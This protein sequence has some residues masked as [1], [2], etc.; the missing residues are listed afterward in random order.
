[1]LFL[2]YDVGTLDL[3]Q[4][5]DSVFSRDASGEI[6]DFPTSPIQSLLLPKLRPGYSYNELTCRS[7][8]KPNHVPSTADRSQHIP[9]AENLRIGS[10]LTSTPFSKRPFHHEAS[11]S[12]VLF[13]CYID[14]WRE[15]RNYSMV[16]HKQTLLDWFETGHKALS[17]DTDRDRSFPLPPATFPPS[18]ANDPM[19]WPSQIIN[20]VRKKT[21]PRP[22]PPSMPVPY[23]IWSRGSCHWIDASAIN[24]RWLL[25]VS[26]QRLVY[27]NEHQ[28]GDDINDAGWLY[29]LDFNRYHVRRLERE[30]N[31]DFSGSD[32]Q[33]SYHLKTEDSVCSFVGGGPFCEEMI[34]GVPYVRSVLRESFNGGYPIVM[35]EERIIGVKV[36]SLCSLSVISTKSSTA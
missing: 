35:D 17:E 2:R 22:Q 12:V 10:H 3:F 18:N 24:V 29:I 19:V 30:L 8:P 7:E 28:D 14:S 9:P 6:F 31:E 27:V 34:N 11:D 15:I 26:G 32:E 4:L 33:R 1:M 20:M 16:L 21:D 25:S 23:S 5:P 13:H 36:R